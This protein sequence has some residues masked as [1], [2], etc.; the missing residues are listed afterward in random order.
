LVEV[1]VMLSLVH[2]AN[3]ARRWYPDAGRAPA[4]ATGALRPP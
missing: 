4:S 1:P 3:R 2:L